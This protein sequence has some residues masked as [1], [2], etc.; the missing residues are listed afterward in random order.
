GIIGT[1]AALWLYNHF[2]GFL[3]ILG[4]T[5]PPIGAIILADFFIL[6]RANYKAFKK[7]TFKRINW[8]AIFAWIVG[9]GSASLLPV[10]APINALIASALV[11]V[12]GTK[13]MEFV[14]KKQILLQQT[15]K[16]RS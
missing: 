14:S 16:V 12:I 11:H 9:V 8:V 1:L 15:E 3:N 2:V 10:I 7:M 5:L 6:N 13:V 4:S